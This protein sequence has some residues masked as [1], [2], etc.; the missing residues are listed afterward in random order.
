MADELPLVTVITPTY[1]RAGFLDETIRSVLAQDYPRVEYIVLDDGSSDN[2][3]DVLRRYDGRLHWET[4]PNMG[5]TRTVNK[6]FQMAK[7]EIVC[8]VNSDDPLLPGALRKAVE[9]LQSNPDALVAYTDWREIGPKSETIQD[10]RLP[11]YDLR[12]MLTEYNVAI[13]PGTFI[14]RRAFEVVGYRSLERRYTGDLE[15]WFRV[16]LKSKLV[17]VPD[18]LATHRTHPGAASSAARGATMASE[19]V[20]L[21]R[22][23]LASPGLPPDLRRMRRDIL[24]NVYGVARHYCG[25]SHVLRCRYRLMQAWYAPRP[26][27]RRKVDGSVRLIKRVLR[28]VAIPAFAACEPLLTRLFGYAVRA[29]LAKAAAARDCGAES[30]RALDRLAPVI[31]PIVGHM[32][33][34]GGGTDACL[35]A[36]ALPLPVHFYSPVPDLR[37]LEALRVW[38]RRSDLAGIDFRPLAQEE[39]LLALGRAHGDECD[40]PATLQEGDPRFHTENNSFSF[41]CAAALHCILRANKPRR[42]IE[43][44]SGYSSKVIAGALAMN[45]AQGAPCDYT[46]IDPYPGDFVRNGGA[47]AREVVAK[48]VETTAPELFT[49]LGRNDVLFIDSGHTV[50]I[51]SDVNFLFLDVLPR[52]APGVIVHVHDIHLPYE[53]PRVYFTNPRFRVLWTEAYLLQAFLSLNR[54]FEVLLG[55][56]WIMRERMDTFRRAFPHYDPACHKLTS[57]SFW[58][59]RN[60]PGE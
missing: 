1:N 33:R 24:E 30:C 56:C 42:V 38:D 25:A 36:G 55:M 46:I 48:C 27:L 5:E 50:R 2:T 17:H 45:R 35:Q 21:G 39:Y 34:C 7:G 8:V 15:Y 16:A 58:I 52:L 20:S 18:V 51:G 57:G 49:Q 28:P 29:R 4:H 6:G 14:R 59:R 9:A 43:V 40:W 11:D 31:A 3:Q 41:G 54:E 23:V 19:L 13:G 44:G 37:E 12:K 47:K 60:L 22:S 32:A 53:Y 10:V 26:I